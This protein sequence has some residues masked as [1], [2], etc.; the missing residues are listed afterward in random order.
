M[1]ILF[2]ISILLT[3]E[4]CIVYAINNFS[5]SMYMLHYKANYT[6]IQ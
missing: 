2:Q 3:L 1:R 6:V 4:S 5:Y